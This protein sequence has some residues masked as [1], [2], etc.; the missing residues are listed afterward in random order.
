[1]PPS[2]DWIA[3]TEQLLR[4]SDDVLMQ[5]RHWNAEMQAQVEHGRRLVREHGE[6]DQATSAAAVTRSEVPPPEREGV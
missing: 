4:R 1:M 2:N 3:D 5:L 6:D